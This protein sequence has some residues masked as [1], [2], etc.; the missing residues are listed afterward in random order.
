MTIT[1]A[2]LIRTAGAS[3]VAAGAIFIGVQIGHPQLNATSITSTDVFV[4]DQL[5]V[6]MCGLAVIGITG[7]YLSQIRR[8][9]LLGLIGYV[10]MAAGYLGIMCV[11]FAAAYI[12][13]EVAPA[14]ARYVNDVIAVDTG[15]GKVVGDVG[16]LQ[17]VIKVAGFAYLLGGLLLGIALYR[18]HVLARWAAALLAI[19]GLASAVLTLMPDAFY[20][21][22]AWP[23]GIAMIGLGFSLW[24]TTRTST[25]TTQPS[26]VTIPT[27]RQQPPSESSTN[28]TIDDS[29]T[30]SSGR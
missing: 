20:R 12:F 3:A 14:S 25:T 18:A 27:P 30:H 5:K 6:L 21:L 17:T 1:P 24:H 10:V 11:T 7:M 8:N 22:L 15:R 13:P 9:G 2:V 16:A 28:T 23:N 26:A 19:G 4:R 29:P